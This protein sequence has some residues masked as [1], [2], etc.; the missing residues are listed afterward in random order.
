MIHGVLAAVP[1][2]T[3]EGFYLHVE[4]LGCCL[5]VVVVAVIAAVAFTMGRKRGQ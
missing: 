2:Q 3:T 5:C 1:S 4:G